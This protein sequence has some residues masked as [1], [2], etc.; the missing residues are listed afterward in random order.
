MAPDRE[1]LP[2]MLQLSEW[3]SSKG[4]FALAAGVFRWDARLCFDRMHMSQGFDGWVV[5]GRIV[6]RYS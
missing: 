5:S 2:R 6:F 1:G 4:R 3:M